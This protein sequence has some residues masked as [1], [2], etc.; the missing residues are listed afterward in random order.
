M[1]VI[2]YNE[3]YKQIWDDLVSISRNGTFLLYR[4]YMDYHKER[5][6]DCSLLFVEKD[7][8]LVVL[9]ACWDEA[10]NQIVSHAGLT[11]GGFICKKETTA[12]QI[13]DCWEEAM[14]YYRK[15]FS[16]K[17]FIYK[18]VPQIYHSYPTEEDLY[19]LFRKGAHLRSRALS[20]TIDLHHPIKM[21]NSRRCGINRAQKKGYIIDDDNNTSIETRDIRL[22]EYWN[23]LEDVLN[24]RHDTHPTHTARE[25][26]LLIHT[27]PDRIK[28]HT[29]SRDGKVIGG[30]VLYLMYD[31]VHVQYIAASAEG[32]YDGALDYLFYQL[33]G[34]EYADRHYFDF[35][36]ST[37]AGGMILNEG[38]L[39]QKEGFGGRGICYDCYEYELD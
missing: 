14:T 6:H 21:R 39:F 16:I 20:S 13:F 29:I 7:V 8:V 34:T 27:F 26:N 12:R 25:M 38:L 22:N 31:I 2:P 9:P 4:D 32:R 24:E 23:V 1:Q 17:R 5:F 30:V 33:I 28:L 11:Y 18:P 19:L 36:I 37:E 35:G 10:N 3:A 15:M